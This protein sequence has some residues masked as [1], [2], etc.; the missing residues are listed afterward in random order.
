MIFVVGFSW[1]DA[2]PGW[3]LTENLFVEAIAAGY[4][5]VGF[6]CTAAA[7][8]IRRQVSSVTASACGILFILVPSVLDIFLQ[9]NAIPVSFVWGWAL[10]APWVLGGVCPFVH[11]R[12]AML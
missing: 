11:P 7:V 10:I 6:I 8:G 9:R 2:S 12:R 5:F 1:T 3:Q 4:G